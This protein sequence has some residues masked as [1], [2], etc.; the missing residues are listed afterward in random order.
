M[1]L[2]D[3]SYLLHLPIYSMLLS[4]ESLTWDEA[5]QMTVE[6]LG[7]D[8]GDAWKVVNDTKG[9][10]A[11]F[12]YLKRIFK[13]RLVEAQEAYNAGNTFSLLGWYHTLE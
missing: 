10:H 12:R 2:D 3:V 1:T 7:D 11:R 8:L 9:R 5:D 4:H 6:H 13:E